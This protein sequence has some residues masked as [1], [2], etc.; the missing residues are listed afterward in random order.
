MI[1]FYHILN[2]FKYQVLSRLFYVVPLVLFLHQQPTLGVIAALK[3]ILVSGRARLS[4]LLLFFKDDFVNHEYLL[5]GGN[6]GYILEAE[7]CL[8]FLLL[9][10]SFTLYVQT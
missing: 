1:Q 8:W 5:T 6:L 7:L 10:C 4:S 3:L 2:S 9:Y